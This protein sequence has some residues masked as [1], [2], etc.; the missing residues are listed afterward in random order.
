MNY[1]RLGQSGMCP[2]GKKGWGLSK[3]L[4]CRHWW[5]L[6]VLL[7]RRVML[8]TGQDTWEVGA[9]EAWMSA[10][11]TLPSAVGLST[12]YVFKIKLVNLEFFIYFTKER[13]LKCPVEVCCGWGIAG[14]RPADLAL[15]ISELAFCNLFRVPCACSS[16]ASLLASTQGVKGGEYTLEGR[17]VIGVGSG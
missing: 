10:F 11:P 16:E 15:D 9:P 8:R 1:R 13:S 17:P 2:M 12:F 14:G 4:P 5:H 7:A 6:S 3:T